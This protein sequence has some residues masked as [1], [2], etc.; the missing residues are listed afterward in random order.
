MFMWLYIKKEKAKS[1]TTGMISCNSCYNV[2]V[3]LFGGC[4]PCNWGWYSYCLVGVVRQSLYCNWGWYSYCLV[5]VVRQSLSCNWRWY[6]Y[7]LVG[8]VRQSLS[9]NWGWYK[10][11]QRQKHIHLNFVTSIYFIKYQI[12]L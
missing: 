4:V 12:V 7:C 9:C 1:C 10:L 6:S 2:T 11:S 8:V 5:G 3:H